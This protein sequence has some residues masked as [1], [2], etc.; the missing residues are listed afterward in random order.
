METAGQYLS[1]MLTVHA[2]PHKNTHTQKERSLFHLCQG[3]K[4]KNQMIL[5]D[6]A[7]KF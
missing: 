5:V 3:E 4:T 6:N 2:H 7:N 1:H